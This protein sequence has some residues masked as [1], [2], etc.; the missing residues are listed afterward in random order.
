MTMIL[1]SGHD[2]NYFHQAKQDRGQGWSSLL[3]GARASGWA[4]YQTLQWS[5]STWPLDVFAFAG[6]ATF[7]SFSPPSCYSFS[8]CFFLLAHTACRSYFAGGRVVSYE[9]S[10]SYLMRGGGELPPQCKPCTSVL[11]LDTSH[12]CYGKGLSSVKVNSCC[13]LAR[14]G[15]S[16]EHRNLG[17]PH[18][19]SETF[20]V[21]ASSQPCRGRRIERGQLD[22]SPANQPGLHVPA[23]EFA[24][25]AANK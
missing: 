3:N 9:L 5:P 1:Y 16:T 24:S 10:A 4:W 19:L 21:L 11:Y 14:K 13:H 23:T 6:L 22:R 25:E 8:G 7:P 15:N 18:I 2:D 12:L 17:T 20:A